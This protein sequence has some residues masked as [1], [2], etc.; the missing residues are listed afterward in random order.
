MKM[1]IKL[2]LI[3][4]MSMVVPVSSIYAN[5]APQVRA[6][7]QK[8]GQVVTNAPTARRNPNSAIANAPAIRQFM[9]LMQSRRVTELSAAIATYHRATG[10]AKYDQLVHIAS[11]FDRL[12]LAKKYNLE[13]HVQAFSVA[14]QAL[15]AEMDSRGSLTFAEFQD[16][17]RTHLNQRLMTHPEM[18]LDP[19]MASRARSVR[20]ITDNVVGQ[21][22][23]SVDFTA[24]RN[25]TEV[26]ANI[27]TELYNR[28]EREDN[29]GLKVLADQADAK[30][31]DLL[32]QGIVVFREG[33]V[34]AIQ[35]WDASFTP[36]IVKMIN[37]AFGIRDN[38]SAEQVT[39]QIRDELER[40]FGTHNNSMTLDQR[41]KRLRECHIL[42]PAA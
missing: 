39:G 1:S 2:T 42:A 40:M 12:E 34:T 19:N 30:L 20:Q 25:A 24:R 8:M 23:N 22:I 6:V 41:I 37:L 29:S 36:G 17:S 33:A 21:N 7:A 14:N 16:L 15:V 11:E 4:S 27:K 5:I 32:S 26:I 35:T 10:D 38:T 3:L 18:Y 28:A 13:R 31:R 9:S